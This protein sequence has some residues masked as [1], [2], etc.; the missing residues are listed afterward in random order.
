VS[1]SVRSETVTQQS[2]WCTHRAGRFVFYYLANSYAASYLP[3]LSRRAERAWDAMQAW[4]AHDE[5]SRSPPVSGRAG[6]GVFSAS[7]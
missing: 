4:H 6:A 1:A 2:D 3:W 5:G 7:A